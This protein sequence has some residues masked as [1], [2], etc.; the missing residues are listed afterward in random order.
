MADDSVVA[1]AEPHKIIRRVDAKAAGLV[2]YFTGKPCPEGHIA[3][4]YVASFGCSV[5][6]QA[7]RARYYA[8]DPEKFRKKA[9]DRFHDRPDIAAARARRYRAANLDRLRA[10]G[11]ERQRAAR[12]KNKAKFRERD[13]A[14]ERA[15]PETVAARKRRERLRN[16]GVFR[17]RVAERRK[18]IRRATPGWADRSA[19]RAVY[20]EAARLTAET[21]VLYEVD[22]IDPLVSG[23]VCGLHIADNL[24]IIPASEN[25]RKSNK[26]SPRVV[27]FASPNLC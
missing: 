12:Q 7:H 15:H 10:E 27:L 23:V 14:W 17:M 24:Q 21:G 6:A 22:H 2:R 25:R 9:R 1:T 20:I 18:A 16:P 8:E 13:R 5:C 19:I 3:E 26:F 11:A 4:R